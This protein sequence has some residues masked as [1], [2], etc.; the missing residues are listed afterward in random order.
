MESLH[1]NS[2]TGWDHEPIFVARSTHEFFS[3]LHPMEKKG[4]EAGTADG[5][6]IPGQRFRRAS[7]PSP[8]PGRERAGVRVS[9]VGP[10]RDLS[11]RGG[12]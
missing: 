1:F 2:D 8:F 5:S 4:E 12:V 3:L 6:P 11:N 9:F 7:S 10:A